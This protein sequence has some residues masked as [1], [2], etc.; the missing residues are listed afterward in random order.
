MKAGDKV[1][2]TNKF[3]AYRG[4]EGV[5]SA[6]TEDEYGVM[7]FVIVGNKQEVMVEPSDVKVAQ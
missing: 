3:H 4:V 6:V 1:V 2:I 5:V 7:V